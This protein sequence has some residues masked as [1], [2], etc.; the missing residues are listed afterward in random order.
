MDKTSQIH[1]FIERNP[2]EDLGGFLI[3]VGV[4]LLPGVLFHFSKKTFFYPSVLLSD[5]AARP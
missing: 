4:F 1:H 3:G 2:R 5:K